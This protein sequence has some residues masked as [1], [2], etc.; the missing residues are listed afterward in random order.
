MRVLWIG[1]KMPVPPVDG[2]RLLAFQTLSALA[3]AGVE[4]TL[5]APGLSDGTVDG[6]LAAVCRP[7]RVPASPRPALA[8]FLLS[9]AGGRPYSIV[10]HRVAA[11]RR[12]VE[13]RLARE[14]FDL[15]HAEQLQAFPQAEPA[16]ARGLP[17][18]LRAQNVESDLWAATAARRPLLRPWLSREARRLAAWEGEVVRRATVTVALTAGDG[19]RLAELAGAGEVVVLPAPFPPR[20]PAGTEPLPG[21]PPL[22]L[23]AGGGWYPNRDGCRWFLREIWPRVRQRAPGARLH[24]FGGG[25]GGRGAAGEEGIELHPAPADSRQAYAPGSVMVVPLRIASGVR[26]KILEAWAR[27][28]PVLATPR[29]AAGLGAEDGRELLLAEDGAGFARAVERLAAEPGL[30]PSLI[31]AG[32][33][34]LVENHDPARV[35]AALVSAYRRAVEIG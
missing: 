2:G 6:E 12:A 35:A 18:V 26:M 19:A 21:Q 23:L 1:T 29:A 33:R 8:A 4:I 17:V 7:R 14:P 22:V 16:L 11:V 30:A 20:L 31:A 5:V 27:G 9:L 32:R 13:E 10:R 25:F 34:R 15:V 28:V 3:S 24:L